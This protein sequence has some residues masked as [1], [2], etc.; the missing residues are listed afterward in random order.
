MAG[1]VPL[2]GAAAVTEDDT[3]FFI[4]LGESF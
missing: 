2:A 1:W 4:R 3:V